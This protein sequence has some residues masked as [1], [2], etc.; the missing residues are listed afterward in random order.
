[1]IVFHTAVTT[2]QPSPAIQYVPVTG[3]AVPRRGVC[4]V[5][6]SVGAATIAI[7]G[8]LDSTHAWYVIKSVTA[9]EA[10]ECVLMPEMRA[11]ISGISGGAAVTVGLEH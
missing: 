11:V 7:Q 3:H 2:N 4:Q 5:S 1:M 8:R 10:F 6:I 9:N